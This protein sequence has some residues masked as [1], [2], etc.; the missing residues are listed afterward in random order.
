MRGAGEL[1]L[2][3]SSLIL[4]RRNTKV[5]SLSSLPPIISP[6]FQK[7][8]GVLQPPA[9]QRHSNA[10][11][12]HYAASSSLSSI[13]ATQHLPQKS[14]Q[15]RQSLVIIMTKCRRWGGSEYGAPRYEP[16]TLSCPRTTQCHTCTWLGNMHVAC[17][18]HWECD[19]G[20]RTCMICRGTGRKRDYQL[21]RG[22][23]HI[24]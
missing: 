24:R 2:N 3:V 23:R 15:T 19:R 4:L 16:L 5:L 20:Y 17:C 8:I 18:G 12:Q 22:R 21:C 1:E 11:T 9:A 6:N 14:S 10:A 7:Y 13:R